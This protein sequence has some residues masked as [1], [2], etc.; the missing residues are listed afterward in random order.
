M[1]ICMYIYIYLLCIY[2]H[3]HTYIRTYIH[4]RTVQTIAHCEVLE[5]EDLFVI[6]RSNISS[7]TLKHL[8]RH[9][10]NMQHLGRR[11]IH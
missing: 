10:I 11:D 8:N 6:Q 7:S 9:N 2:I 5:G 3:I 1:C 4:I